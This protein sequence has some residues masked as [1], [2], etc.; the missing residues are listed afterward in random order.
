MQLSKQQFQT[1]FCGIQNLA[2]VRPG[3]LENV[4]NQE[5]ETCA[6]IGQ[7]SSDARVWNSRCKM[8]GVASR[9]L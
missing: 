8:A 1:P 6:T 7:T 9:W 2:F 4:T 5:H 3:N